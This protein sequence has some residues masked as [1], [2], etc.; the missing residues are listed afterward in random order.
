[1]KAE[2]LLHTKQLKSVLPIKARLS[3]TI[4]GGYSTRLRLIV[5]T[6]A[7]KHLY[8][9]GRDGI[10]P[11]SDVY[12]DAYSGLILC[13]S[14]QGASKVE[15][16][17][18]TTVYLS[19]A[20]K[21]IASAENAVPA[22]EIDAV[23]AIYEDGSRYLLTGPLPDQFLA[24]SVRER[25]R[26]DE[27]F[28]PLKAAAIA[29][30]FANIKLPDLHPGR[31]PAAVEEPKKIETVAKT[32]APP[33]ALSPAPLAAT[34]VETA[35][36]AIA[37]DF[38]DRF[39]DGAKSITDIGEM[40]KMLNAEAIRL[41]ETGSAKIEFRVDEKGEVRASASVAASFEL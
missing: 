5:A 3:S 21:T 9:P 13:L 10:N 11:R 4:Q 1:M 39:K 36:G 35:S 30:D 7:F 20:A 40:L 18:K 34:H 22:T 31:A 19:F 27:N 2:E 33:Q 15:Q 41:R 32:P 37:E 25:R 26:R 14:P 29:F 23:I 28:R 24:T 6:D 12:G 8:N 16:T 17:T 38:F